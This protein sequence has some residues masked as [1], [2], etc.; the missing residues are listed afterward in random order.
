MSAIIPISK[1]KETIVSDEDSEHFSK[2][3]WYS[4]DSR[5]TRSIIKDGRQTTIALSREIWAWHNGPIAKGLE[6]DHINGDVLDNR[7]ENL[8]PCTRSQ[9]GCNKHKRKQTTSKF[10][11]A[12]KVGEKWLGVILHKNESY[13]LGTFSTELE[14]ARAYDRKAKELFGEFAALNF[15]E[16]SQ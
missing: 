10:K 6:I 14:A 5:A 3:K 9:N 2:F 16:G 13:H 8:R 15:P 11:G 4:F 1:G 12:R 7:L